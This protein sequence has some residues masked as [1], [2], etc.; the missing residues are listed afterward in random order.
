MQT[1]ELKRLC[2]QKAE[3][4]VVLGIGHPGTSEL[5][6]L[7]LQNAQNQGQDL[8]KYSEGHWQAERQDQ[9]LEMQFLHSKQ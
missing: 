3:W 9:K 8:C 2:V 6:S 4:I 1:S 5:A 7:G